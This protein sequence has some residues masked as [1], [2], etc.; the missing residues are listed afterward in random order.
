[1]TR[2]TKTKTKRAPTRRVQRTPRPGGGAASR[3]ERSSEKTRVLQAGT[4]L[5]KVVELLSGVGGASISELTTQTGW[6]PHTTRAALT[7]LRKRGFAIDT[8]RGEHGTVYRL[9]LPKPGGAKRVGRDAS[10]KV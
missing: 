4:K 10:P 1:M 9:V 8:E 3:I 7:G 2:S 5:S 6:L